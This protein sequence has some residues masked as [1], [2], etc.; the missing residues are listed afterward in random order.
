MAKKILIVDDEFYITK[1]LS[2]MFN[3]EGY[4]CLAVSNGQAAIEKI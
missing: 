2:F 3:K 1:S 4:E